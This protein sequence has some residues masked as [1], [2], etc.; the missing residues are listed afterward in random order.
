MAASI[1]RALS[2]WFLQPPRWP[3]S[4]EE[5]PLDVWAVPG[6][7]TL[8]DVALQEAVEG[9]ITATLTSGHKLLLAW[10][11][12][13]RQAI[14]VLGALKD[15]ALLVPLGTSLPPN[16]G[17]FGA[18]RS[19][20]EGFVRACLEAASDA[21]DRIGTDRL[22]SSANLLDPYESVGGSS[23]GSG[24][25]GG[26]A[27]SSSAASSHLQHHY[28]HHASLSGV[29][30]PSLPQAVDESTGDTARR[31]S[32]QTVLR[33]RDCWETPRL[34]CVDYVWADDVA[35]HS[36]RLLRQLARQ[37]S[38]VE[39]D[40]SGSRGSTNDLE[41]HVR[42]LLHL[43]Q[44]DLPSRLVQFRTSVEADSCVLKRLYLVKC[45]YRAPLR[46]FLEAHQSVF[47]APR[48]DLVDEFMAQASAPSK[49]SRRHSSSSGSSSSSTGNDSAQGRLSSL[50]E[51]ETVL[52][53]LA[54]EKAASEL[55]V[56]MAKVLYPFTELA[57]H[58]DHKRARPRLV[59]RLLDTA[60]DLADVQ[61]TL[62]RLKFLLCRKAGP[63]S[64]S[65][66]RPLLL[67]LQG[68]PRDEEVP[69]PAPLTDIMSPTSTRYA[70]VDEE[71]MTI[72]LENL[73]V[74]LETLASMAQQRA[75]FYADR[76]QS[77]QRG[78]GG[79]GGSGHSGGDIDIP[80]SIVRGCAQF[81]GEMF[82]CQFQDWYER[83]SRQHE[84]VK[85]YGDLDAFAERLRQAEM[86]MSLSVAP[87]SSLQVVRERVQAMTEDR[88]KRFTVLREVLEEVCLREMSLHVR[89]SAP[90]KTKQ[91]V[92]QPTSAL[93]VFGLPMAGEVLP[94]G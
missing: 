58:L 60:E 4:S 42:V 75:G 65:G 50:L 59:P 18:R 62:R 12:L 64:S 66:I 15:L 49:S 70:D 87:T 14:A 91:L 22:A 79:G 81:D 47:K 44:T 26:S 43:L 69:S 39:W 8:L 51:N 17:G 53:A 84:I 5:T 28:Y 6:L 94:L 85:Q 83:V 3:G 61:E 25:G 71:S 90:D 27:S 11:D 37:A 76:P 82:T 57:R 10:F 29:T 80:A 89:L 54:L 46:G 32:P 19:Q 21:T 86:Q 38:G 24:G 40:L 9:E 36:L 68:V 72:R 7:A 77:S 45:E 55:E 16:G 33:G 48:L 67:D 63:D 2:N 78:G 74:E 41:R 52:E 93:G 20:M 13:K 73:V 56:D 31:F 23:S 34:H 35:S 30:L 92:L 88:E 1:L